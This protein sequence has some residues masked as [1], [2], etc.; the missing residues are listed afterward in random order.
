MALE[1]VVGRCRSLEAEVVEVDLRRPIVY[2]FGLTA[3]R[4]GRPQGRYHLCSKLRPRGNVA[5]RRR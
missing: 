3:L 4:A 5:L 2:G 1:E